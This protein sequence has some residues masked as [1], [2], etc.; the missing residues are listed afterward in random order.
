MVRHRKKP[1]PAQENG[2]ASAKRKLD[3]EDVASE[4][5]VTKS[6]HDSIATADSAV[7]DEGEEAGHERAISPPRGEEENDLFGAGLEW[8][9]FA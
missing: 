8:Y 5:D 7:N 4:E 1:A 2:S 6:G 9:L 3:V